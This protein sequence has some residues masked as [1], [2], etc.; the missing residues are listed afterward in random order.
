M[1]AQAI[2]FLVFCRYMLAAAALILSTLFSCSISPLVRHKKQAS[3]RT[4]QPSIFKNTG[5]NPWLVTAKKI[6]FEPSIAD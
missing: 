1:E 4:A 6:N 3:L 5:I 2:F